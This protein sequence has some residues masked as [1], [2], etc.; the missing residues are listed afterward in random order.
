MSA[1]VNDK[2]QL[3]SASGTV[4]N[5]PR[6]TATRSAAGTSLTVD[7]CN[8]DTTTGKIF[9]TYQVDTSGSVVA[10]TQTIWKGVVN[11]STSIGSMTRL[12]GASDTGNA[13]GDYV[14]IIP[15]SEWVNNLISGVLAQHNQDGTHSDI[16]ATTADFTG[17]V[18][19][20]TI[21]E[22]TAASGVTVD[23]MNIKDGY[24]VGSAT[25]GI[26][27]ESLGTAATDLGSAWQSW[28]P[29]LSGRFNDGKWTKSCTYKQVGK[30]VVCKLLLT[31]NAATP[32]DGSGDPVF[33][34]PVTSVSYPNSAF[35]ALAYIE[36]VGTNTYQAFT[37]WGSTTTASLSVP[38]AGGTY[39]TQVQITNAVPHTWASTDVIFSIFTYE[40]A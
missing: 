13:I 19:A 15:D 5:V 6:V 14:E 24:V 35:M 10:G 34:L 33:T 16:T 40:A 1:S 17:A 39:V 12:A 31:A 7:N 38:V 37:R 3:I 27:N 21:S 22:H 18:S 26:K 23:G 2:F 32:M 25:S 9:S 29:T 28:T 11:S 20:N 8:W 4:P 36:D 30:T